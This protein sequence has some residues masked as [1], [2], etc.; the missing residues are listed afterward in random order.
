[1]TQVVKNKQI[2]TSTVCKFL[3]NNIKVIKKNKS[4]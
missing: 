4:K 3:I 1:M 2:K